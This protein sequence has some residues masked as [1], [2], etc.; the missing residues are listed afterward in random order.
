MRLE[1]LRRRVQTRLATERGSFVYNPTIGS[2]FFKMLRSK[3]VLEVRE[4]IQGYAREALLPEIR[5]GFILGVAGVRIL[6]LSAHSFSVEID[7]IA[8]NR[9]IL[10]VP[11]EVI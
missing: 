10:T 4:R 2:Q 11:V 7:V 8:N 9:Q 1:Q 3:N 6:R 5:K